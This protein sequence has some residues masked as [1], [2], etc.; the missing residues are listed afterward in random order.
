MSTQ[1]ESGD[2][3]CT[4]DGYSPDCPRAFQQ[5]GQILHVLSQKDKLKPRKYMRYDDD[6]KSEDE[7]GMKPLVFQNKK[8]TIDRDDPSLDVDAFLQQELSRISGYG[9]YNAGK[10]SIQSSQ[11]GRGRLGNDNDMLEKNREVLRKFE[12]LEI[13]GQSLTALSIGGY[14]VDLTKAAQ[15]AREVAPLPPARLPIIFVDDTLNFYH[16]FFQGLEIMIGRNMFDSI[17]KSA[18]YYDDGDLIILSMISDMIH[19]GYENTDNEITVFTKKVLTSTFEI[20]EANKN[21]GKYST[22]TAVANLWGFQ[23]IESGMQCRESDLKMWISNCYNYYRTIWFNT[24]KSAGIPKFALD[25]VQ[26][27]YQEDESKQFSRSNRDV[28]YHEEKSRFTRS[29]VSFKERPSRYSDDT[30]RIIRK[31]HKVRK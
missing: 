18:K 14:T 12:A 31:S 17:M 20:D 26:T 27:R 9:P 2:C 19:R 30:P 13:S 5:G 16:H 15:K 21:K 1:R 11:L 23:Y 24:F 29:G 10:P 8:N 22:V 6:H 25:G 7:S 4:E 3:T 28:G